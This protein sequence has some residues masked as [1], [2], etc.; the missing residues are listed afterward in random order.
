[1]GL[2][3]RSHENRPPAYG[4]SNN[5]AARRNVNFNT[6]WSVVATYVF[7]SRQVGVLQSLPFSDARPD[8]K[9]RQA[10]ARLGVLL[11]LKTKQSTERIDVIDRSVI[12][13]TAP[14]YASRDDRCAGQIT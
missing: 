10:T 9:L 5:V 6:P 4:V 13:V 14:S 8:P 3:A 2:L 12:P 7:S 11:L 1:L